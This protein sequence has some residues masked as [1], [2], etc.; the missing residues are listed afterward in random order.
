MVDHSGKEQIELKILIELKF[1]ENLFE[2]I[3][4]LKTLF[5]S[6]RYLDRLSRCEDLKFS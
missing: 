3:V 1:Y 2:K 4:P 5:H 6:F